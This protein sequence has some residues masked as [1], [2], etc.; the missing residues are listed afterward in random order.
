[1]SRTLSVTYRTGTPATTT[2]M[3]MPPGLTVQE[4]IDHICLV[5]GIDF[6]QVSLDGSILATIT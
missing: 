6:D 3:L 4:V 2:V 1:M 5:E